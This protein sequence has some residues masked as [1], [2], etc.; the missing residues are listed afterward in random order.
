VIAHTGKDADKGIRGSSALRANA[1]FAVTMK[2]VDEDRIRMSTKPEHGG[3]MKNAPQDFEM[4]LAVKPVGPSLVLVDAARVEVPTTE[5]S[6]SNRNRVLVAFA[7]QASLGYVSQSQVR[8][9]I[10]DDGTHKGALN[11]GT[12][13]SLVA[14]LVR[15]GVLE[16][17]GSKKEYRLNPANLIAT[18]HLEAL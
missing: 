2:R 9:V 17:N 12:V 6:H 3:K 18:R 10:A 15:E 5:S 14:D 11:P 16:Q 7:Q 1:D 4:L 13:S 8:T